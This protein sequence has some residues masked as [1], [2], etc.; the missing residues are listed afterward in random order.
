MGRGLIPPFSEVREDP[1]AGGL[2]P[3]TKAQI[4]E[5]GA[6]LHSPHLRL[7]T[8]HSPHLHFLLPSLK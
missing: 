7:L 1:S 5:G 3:A 6:L 4:Q 2:A 8:M